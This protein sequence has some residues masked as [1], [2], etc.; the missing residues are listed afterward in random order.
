MHLGIDLGTSGLKLVVVDDEGTVVTEHEQSLTYDEPRPGWAEA[1]PLGWASTVETAL[2]RVLAAAPAPA[3]RDVGVTGQMH[4]AVLVDERG[5]PVRPA[6]LWP[7]V[8]AAALEARWAALP[9]PA[10]VLL[11]GPFSPGLTGPVLAWLAEHEPGSVDR[12]ARVLLAKDFL[13]GR[14]LGQEHEKVVTDPGDA[15]GTLLWDVAA[16]S[17]SAAAMAAAGVAASLLPGVASADSGAGLW[18]DR[19]VVVG[20]GDTPASLLAL[21]RGLGGWRPGDVVV[22]LGT[23]AQ[24]IA[25]GTP[26]PADDAPVGWHTYADGVGGHYAMVALQN[27]GLALTWA[28]QRLGLDWPAFSA[29]AAAERPG[30][31]GVVFRPFV[32]PERGAMRPPGPETAGWVGPTTATVGQRARAA[33]EA[34]A[35]LVRRACDLIAPT[36]GRVLL[37]G[38]GGRDAWVRQLLAD[39]LQHPVTRVEIRSASALGAALLAAGPGLTPPLGTHVTDPQA[40]RDLQDAYATWG[41]ACYPAAPGPD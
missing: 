30:A 6:I 4:G 21:A 19:P 41:D 33:A 8:R 39:V 35:F 38:G 2:A 24:V 37:V 11:G 20:T 13:R 34:Y 40:A 32:A 36:P 23:G 31:G 1:D 16:G 27:G 12:T 26:P 17:W 29:Y 14:L 28:R 5:A 3:V 10:R 18:R 7:D 25:P 9:L 15:S 22:N